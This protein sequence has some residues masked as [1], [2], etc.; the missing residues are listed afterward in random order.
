MTRVI[1]APEAIELLERAV[2]A[3]GEDYVDPNAANGDG[4][5]YGDEYGHPACIV[6]HVVFYLGINPDAIKAGSVYRAISVDG[7][8]DGGL[9]V[10][11]GSP[12]FTNAARDVLGRAQ[13]VQDNEGTWGAAL[14]AA[15][16][17]DGVT[18]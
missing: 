11:E 16:S 12:K 9:N 2:Q 3:K 13:T 7:V 5:M 4:C 8:L 18:A 10:I 6:G 15:K 1:D 14:T 17:T